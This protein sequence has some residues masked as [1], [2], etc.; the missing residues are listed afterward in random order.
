MTGLG[1]G[2]RNAKSGKMCDKVRAA[3]EHTSRSFWTFYKTTKG[4]WDQAR[5]KE[6]AKGKAV[7]HIKKQNTDRVHLDRGSAKMSPEFFEADSRT[8]KYQGAHSKNTGWQALEMFFTWVR[9]VIAVS[10]TRIK[11]ILSD[12]S[13]CLRPASSYRDATG[14]ESAWHI[15]TKIR[16]V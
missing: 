4:C 14:A 13:V 9:I 15:S 6:K 12:G 11:T 5:W 3:R 1:A 16:D 7:A 2:R 10:G 8:V